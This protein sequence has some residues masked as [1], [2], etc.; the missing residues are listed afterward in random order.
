MRPMRTPRI[1]LL[2]LLGL[3]AY[4]SAHAQA[5]CALRD[6]VAAISEML[7]EADAHR[8]H[9]RTVRK[10][11]QAK[12]RELLDFT[13]MN[14]ELG[15]H[16]L[17]VVSEDEAVIGYVHT[18]TEKGRFGLNEFIWALDGDLN[19]LSYKHQ[20]CRDPARFR[21][22]QDALFALVQGRGASELASMLDGDGQ[23]RPEVMAFNDEDE[24]RYASSL[25]RSGVKT[26]LISRLVWTELF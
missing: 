7:P 24:R 9:V 1:W 19:V 21:V 2:S 18:R 6:P 17:Y 20:R 22:D 12:L 11:H 13:V 26:I 25:V 5:Y 4:A 15:Q 16:T 23:I 8:A 3:L 14:G 10:E